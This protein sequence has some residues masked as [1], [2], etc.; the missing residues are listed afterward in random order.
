MS[1]MTGVADTRACDADRY[2]PRHIR[3][4]FSM[5]SDLLKWPADT[6]S[7]AE[8]LYCAAGFM[9]VMGKLLA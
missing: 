4:V 6:R 1:W 5:K 8:Q 2:G 7:L 3:A 9:L